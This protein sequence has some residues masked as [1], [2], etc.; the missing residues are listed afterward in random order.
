MTPIERI[1][2]HWPVILVLVIDD[3]ACRMRKR[4]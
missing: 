4:R 3:P 2:R 1:M